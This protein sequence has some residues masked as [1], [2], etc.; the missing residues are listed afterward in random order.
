MIHLYNNGFNITGTKE[1]NDFLNRCVSISVKHL[2]QLHFS[3]KLFIKY[4]TDYYDLAIDLI[5]GTFEVKNGT[6]IHFKNYFDSIETLNSDPEYQKRLA[7]YIVDVVNRNLVHYYKSNDPF[8][9]KLLDNVN[10]VI[11]KNGYHVTPLITGRYIHRKIVD[12]NQ[13]LIDR[14]ALINSL[15]IDSSSLDNT[16]AFLDKLFDTLESF[17][18]CVHALPYYEIISVYRELH[19]NNYIN[20]ILTRDASSDKEK[21]ETVFLVRKAFDNFRAVFDSYTSKVG[22]SE[23]T[24]VNFLNIIR[25]IMECYCSSSRKNELHFYLKSY[26]SKDEIILLENKLKYCVNLFENELFSLLIINNFSINS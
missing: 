11:G 5:A 1:L 9:Y 24:S 17:S 14:E 19:V 7:V 6:L 16:S 18:G 23:K 15:N 3:G 22:L 25:E 12:F 26:Y 2:K 13:S 10:L 20:H 8:T 21:F 4:D